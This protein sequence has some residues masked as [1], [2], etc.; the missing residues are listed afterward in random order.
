MSRKCSGFDLRRNRKKKMTLFAGK[1]DE[2]DVFNAICV[3]FTVQKR[4]AP[5][6]ADFAP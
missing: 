3:V 1:F 2:T 5:E 4:N 6:I